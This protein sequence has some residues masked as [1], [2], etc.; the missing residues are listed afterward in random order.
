MVD[1]QYDLE[2][3]SNREPRPNGLHLIGTNKWERQNKRYREILIEMRGGD[4]SHALEGANLA[5]K[6]GKNLER[7]SEEESGHA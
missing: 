2:R 6:L 1:T 5:R 4:R 7:D 3:G